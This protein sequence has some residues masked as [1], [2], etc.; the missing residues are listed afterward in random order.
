MPMEEDFVQAAHEVG[1]QPKTIHD[2]WSGDHYGFYSSLAA[3]DRTDNP[4]TRSYSATGYLKPNLGRKNLKVLTEAL[5]SKVVLRGNE[6][7]GVEFSHGGKNYTVDIAKEVILSAGTIHTPTVLERSGIGDPEVLSKAG[8]EC[9]VENRVVG[10]NFQ[11]HVLSG[12]LFDAAPG[13][14]EVLVV[15]PPGRTADAR[16]LLGTRGLDGRGYTKLTGIIEG[17]TTRPGSPLSP[18]GRRW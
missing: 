2:A 10:H 16:E 9:V 17:G 14:D 12:M 4:G 18:G 6:V 11:D 8:V 5:V 3:V 1:G 7:R 15:M 13:V